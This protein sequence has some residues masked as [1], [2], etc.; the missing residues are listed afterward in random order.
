MSW[1]M[2]TKALKFLSVE[3][4]EVT[5]SQIGTIESSE[6]KLSIIFLESKHGIYNIVKHANQ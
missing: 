3:E 1:M 6:R 4:G 5:D 2:T